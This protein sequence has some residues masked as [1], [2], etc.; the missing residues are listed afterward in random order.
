MKFTITDLASANHQITN[1][2]KFE[3]QKKIYEPY[4]SVNIVFPVSERIGAMKLSV[5]DDDNNQIFEGN[6][7]KVYTY[8]D[9]SG[10]YMDITA[11]SKGALLADNESIPKIFPHNTYV[12]DYYQTYIQPY[13]VSYKTSL[14]ASTLLQTA[15]YKGMSEW[16][17]LAT[18]VLF[19]Y[20]CTPD[21]DEEDNIVFA[22][23][24]LT[25]THTFSNSVSNGIKFSYLCYKDNRDKRY[26]SIWGISEATEEYV[27]MASNST[28][29]S[30]QI[31]RRKL[32][33][34]PNLQEPSTMQL[35]GY[36]LKQC[37]A[38]TRA[39]T[40]RVPGYKSLLTWEKATINDTVFGN[41]SDLFIT[42]VKH[43]IDQNGEYT[44]AELWST[45]SKY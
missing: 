19:S 26:S 22:P 6:A 42:S 21:V 20:G 33:D 13:G 14:N 35:C 25:T 3:M 37:N 29:S 4:T 39:Y 11:R 44:E 32:M 30:E 12:M 15:T 1:A 24:F 16:E 23:G 31:N 40:V 9:D 43:V 38:G 34:Y 28:E 10:K 8:I 41:V 17:A 27:S 2:V 5:Y 45:S 7:D 36:E 18:I